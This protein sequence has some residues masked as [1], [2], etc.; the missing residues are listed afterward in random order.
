[1]NIL[2]ARKFKIWASGIVAVLVGTFLF[3]LLAN[4]VMSAFVVLDVLPDFPVKPLSWVKAAPLES[5]I[6]YPGPDGRQR[7]AYTYQ[8]AGKEKK[9]VVALIH[10]ATTRGA[11]DERLT[12]LAK[13]FAKEGI[14]VALPEIPG[15]IDLKISAGD[16]KEVVYAIKG[17]AD[18]YPGYKVGVMA[19]SYA[20]VLSARAV[21]DP[22][23]KDRVLFL[24]SFGGY[25]SAKSELKY[26]TTGYFDYKGK[27]FNQQPDAYARKVFYSNLAD[28]LDNATDRTVLATV[29]N[30]L[31]DEQFS[32]EQIETL[33][34]DLGAQGRSLW[35]LLSNKNAD[36]FEDLYS[37]LPG[38]LKEM[39]K[40][41]SLDTK[42]MEFKGRVLIAHGKGDHQMPYTESLKLYDSL[43][44]A[45]RA[46][47]EL[48][49]FI[50]HVDFKLPEISIGSLL[51][52]YIPEVKNI[53]SF[54]SDILWE[55]K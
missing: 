53:L 22:L 44:G 1:M 25:Y 21:D 41:M 43:K 28:R 29:V 35:A 50:S 45:N 26:L 6:N 17:I 19:F 33:Y 11:K 47:I 9:T 24:G 4:G 14:A 54:V 39:I 48:L 32:A 12:T 55:S 2:K 20:A 13:S 18:A 23:L 51:D 7:V 46:H 40:Q 15:V 36:R 38:S 27:S 37:K 5:H 10:G 8:A 49:G 3:P 16:T 42:P 30:Q 34:S 31:A 52:F